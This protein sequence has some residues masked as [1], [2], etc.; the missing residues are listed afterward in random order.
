MGRSAD[1]PIGPTDLPFLR[2]AVLQA[3]LSLDC[4]SAFVLSVS[5]SGG[6][7]NP[8]DARV[9]EFDWTAS[10]SFAEKDMIALN[11]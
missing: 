4:V 1:H 9:A 6:P 3:H 5:F 11:F 8:C 10:C 2:G 7:S